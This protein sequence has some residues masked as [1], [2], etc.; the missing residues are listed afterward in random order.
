MFQKREERM[1]EE[2]R[3]VLG[4]RGIR[5]ILDVGHHG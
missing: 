3:R 1:R 5:G 4:A 2:E